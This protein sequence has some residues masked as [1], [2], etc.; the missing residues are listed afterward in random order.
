M[1]RIFVK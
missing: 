1:E